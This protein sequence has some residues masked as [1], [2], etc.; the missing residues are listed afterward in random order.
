MNKIELT[1]EL[2]ESSGLSKLESEKIVNLY[3]NEMSNAPSKGD[4]VEIH[5]FCSFFV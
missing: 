2:K 5:G 3:F 4:S 1:Q